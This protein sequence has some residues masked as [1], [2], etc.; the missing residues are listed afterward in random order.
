L[1]SFTASITPEPL[2]DG[3]YR[4][5][6]ERDWWIERGPNGGHVAAGIV[7]AME[8]EVA[9]PVRQLRSLTV[10]YPAAPREGEAEV[11]VTVERAGRGLSTVS[12]RLT[13]GDRLLALALA[14]FGGPY[15]AAVEYDE[16]PMPAVE[17]PAEMPAPTE[18]D[19]RPPF[20]RQWRMHPAL[21]E[22]ER[23]VTGGWMAPREP[24]PVDA[25]LLVALA[26]T[27]IP[28]PFVVFRGFFPAPT[29]DLSVHIRA[30]LPLE[31]QPVLGEFR[32]DYARDGYFEEDGRL[33]AP[34]GTLLAHS[35]QLAL[36][37]KS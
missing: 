24:A 26:D 34:D 32:S 29:I 15:P 23:A 25:A 4:L 5:R 3:R 1:T 36:A 21:G 7:R 9:D 30:A 14:A 10:H 8:A 28:A 12:A 11:A 13:S 19:D 37:L 27:W 18:R 16:A 31:P 2:G 35:R 20:A 22:H 17:V 33:W 6:Y